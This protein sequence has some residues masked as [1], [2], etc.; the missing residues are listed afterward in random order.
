MNCSS[1]I[2]RSSVRWW[3]TRE[4]PVFDASNSHPNVWWL[5]PN[6]RYMVDHSC[7][8]FKLRSSG[9]TPRSR[10]STVTDTTW[11][12]PTCELGVIWTSLEW[13]KGKFIGLRWFKPYELLKNHGVRFRFSLPV[14]GSKYILIQ[15][16]NQGYGPPLTWEISMRFRELY[17]LR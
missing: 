2:N 6:V 16:F 11:R 14:K 4:P 15:G 17:T 1:S 5:N 10:S 7:R 9:G 8:C 12:L 3:W 13:F